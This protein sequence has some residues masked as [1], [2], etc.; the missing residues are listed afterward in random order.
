[1]LTY[2]LKMYQFFFFLYSIHKPLVR[3]RQHTKKTIPQTKIRVSSLPRLLK[4]FSLVLNLVAYKHGFCAV[5]VHVVKLKQKYIKK[6]KR[7]K[8]EII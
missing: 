3:N 2:S 7:K 8:E 6:K 4:H 1:M 5:S